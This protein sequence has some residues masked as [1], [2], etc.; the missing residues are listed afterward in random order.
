MVGVLSLNILDGLLKGDYALDAKG[1][2]ESQIGLIGHAV[3]GRG[4]D[5]G[6]VEGEY[7]VFLRQQMLRYLFEVGVQTHTE[8]C[9]LLKYLVCQFLLVHCCMSVICWYGF[10]LSCPLSC[11][12]RPVLL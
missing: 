10:L 11:S 6:L 7:R 8:E 9:F 1:F 5:D 12:Q 3:G 2:I 4:I